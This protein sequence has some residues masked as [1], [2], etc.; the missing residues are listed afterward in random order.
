MTT[1]VEPKFRFDHTKLVLGATFYEAC[2]GK[3]EKYTVTIAPIIGEG[4]A[5]MPTMQ[6][7]GMR[8]G[9]NETTPFLVTM[10]MEHYGPK[11]YLE[12]DIFELGGRKYVAR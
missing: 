7:E 5:D 1:P 11:I 3:L 9:S 2:W 6:W 4:Y 10:G 12:E 8:E